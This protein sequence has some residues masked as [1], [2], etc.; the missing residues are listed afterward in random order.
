M[1]KVL[2]IG[3]SKLAIIAVASFLWGIYKAAKKPVDNGW[4]TVVEEPLY[5]RAWRR[6]SG[7]GGSASVEVRKK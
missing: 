2:Q 7:R 4:A 6:L 1:D 3:L 5:E